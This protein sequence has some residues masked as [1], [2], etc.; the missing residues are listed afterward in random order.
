MSKPNPPQRES[1]KK[2]KITILQIFFLIGA[3][4]VI[5]TIAHQYGMLH[6]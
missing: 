4:G 1:R 2:P 3:V 5:L 6:G